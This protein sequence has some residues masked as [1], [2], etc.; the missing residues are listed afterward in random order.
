MNIAELIHGAGKCNILQAQ[1]I[2]KCI[3]DKDSVSN[4]KICS[5]FDKYHACMIISEIR[6]ISKGDALKICNVIMNQ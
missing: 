3:T 2:E 1:V 5:M 4:E 6:G